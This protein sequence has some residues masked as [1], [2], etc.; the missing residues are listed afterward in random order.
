M[1]ILLII[2][3]IMQILLIFWLFVLSLKVNRLKENYAENTRVKKEM[4]QLFESYMFDIRVE[5]ENLLKQLK[6]VKAPSLKQSKSLQKNSDTKIPVQSKLNSFTHNRSH[7]TTLGNITYS[8]PKS[9]II[10][11]VKKDIPVQKEALMSVK[12]EDLQNSNDSTRQ[13]PSLTVRNASKNQSIDKEEV[14][15]QTLT[16]QALLLKEQGMSMDEIAKKLNKGK[17]ELEL[18]LKFRQ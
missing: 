7:E 14:Y 16:A 12:K 4:E 10:G 11:T 8:K 5:N 15:T 1:E 18:L 17:T 2:F 13:I 3:I 9:S 6:E